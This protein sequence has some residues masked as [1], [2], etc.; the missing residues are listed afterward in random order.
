M[1]LYYSPNGVTPATRYLIT[2]NPGWCDFTD[3][4]TE[5]TARMN[6]LGI[7][8]VVFGVTFDDA[9]PNG[10]W[11]YLA[12][13]DVANCRMWFA[14]FYRPNYQNQ[15][16]LYEMMNWSCAAANKNGMAGATNGAFSGAPTLLFTKYVDIVCNNLTA[17]QDVKDGSSSNRP[18]DA[19]CRLYLTDGLDTDPTLGSTPFNVL[20]QYTNPKFIKWENNIPVASMSFQVYNDCGYILTGIQDGVYTESGLGVFGIPNPVELPDWQMSI[21]LSEQ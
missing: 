8:G 19:I 5:L 1:Y 17:V 9:Y 2:L 21:L 13:T 15:K 4:A 16:G 7:A 14:P 20:R 11:A 12:T 6:G 3:L 10:T 18:R